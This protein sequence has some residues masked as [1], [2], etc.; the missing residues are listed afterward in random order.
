MN[1]QSGDTE[2]G[3][4]ARVPSSSGAGTAKVE[5][6]EEGRAGIELIARYRRGLTV[7][8]ALLVLTY[9]GL[10]VRAELQS[11]MGHLRAF[12]WIALV[13]VLGLSLGNY[14][15]RFVRWQFYL[16]RLDIRLDW[17]QSLS[18]FLS[19]L[20][21]TIT[22]GKAGELLKSLLLKAQ[23]GTPFLKSAPVIAAERLTDF[24]ALII[25]AGIG[26]GTYYPQHREWLALVF[27]LILGVT[28]VA[29]SPRL[30]HMVL[31]HAS[32]LP[33]IGKLASA[34]EPAWDAT[35]LLL[36]PRALLVGTLL[37]LSAW[38]A[39]CVGYYGVFWGHGVA[40]TLDVC[41]FLYAFSTLI[42]VVSP[43]G[44]VVTDASLTEGARLL[45][46][47]VSLSLATA[48]A[49]VIRGA[50][51]WFAVLVGSLA[52]LRSSD[53]ISAPPSGPAS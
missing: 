18:I 23:A 3:L 38:F 20:S 30:S 1:G 17:K 27:V 25:L 53:R 50:T 28:L 43:G 31:Q 10:S 19:G 37:S 46:P 5:E 16:L 49:F 22:P 48:A 36:A 29:G 52:L 12:H 2:D 21:M 42:G 40:A 9:A 35:C 32:R 34:L 8:V 26:I 14:A 6:R 39:E 33:W 51:L 11:V 45:I 7:G 24:L 13:P 41:T 4:D 15:I 47:G 44:L